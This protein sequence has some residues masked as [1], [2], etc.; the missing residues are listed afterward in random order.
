MYYASLQNKK[1]LF[2]TYSTRKKDHTRVDSGPTQHVLDFFCSKVQQFTIID[3]PYFLYTTHFAPTAEIYEQGKMVQ[4]YRFPSFFHSLFFINDKRK[5]K[6]GTS[7]RMKIRD[8]FSV[9]FFS[10]K[11]PKR[12]DLFIG[13]ESIN[14]AAGIL[15]KKLGFI[16]TVT[17]YIFDFT[18]RRY[19]NKILNALY[20]ALDKFCCYHADYV[21]NISSAY[22]QARI[23][24]LHYDPKKMAKQITVNY[25][26][27]EISV[28]SPKQ[29]KKNQLIFSG[30]IGE[31]NGILKLIEAMPLVIQTIPDAHLIICGSGPQE[32][33]VKKRIVKL[34]V[35][36]H[37]SF[38][39]F[40]AD[41][42]K[43]IQ[44][45]SQSM[46]A[47][48][49][50]PDLIDSTKKYGDVMKIREYFARGLPVVTTAVPPISR[51]IKKAPAGI[52]VDYTKESIA[53][54]IIELLQN[55]TVYKICQQQVYE[56]AKNNTWEHNLSTAIKQM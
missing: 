22:A 49:P 34:H 6:G 14:T 1:V 56:L 10:L 16:T 36:Q 48:A 13:M 37:V 19:G 27:D 17:Y 5:K 12:Y 44:L 50:Y 30:S 41:K 46:L 35:S 24:E 23:N 33:E 47:V 15:M 52:I 18:P 32:E 2:A 25:G 7:L 42:Q 29:R 55:D 45:Q 3:Q 39:G 43:V 40:F 20:I 54:G 4:S 38:L 11:E 9:I 31:E 8:F 51:E 26:V 21:W 53:Q 28:H